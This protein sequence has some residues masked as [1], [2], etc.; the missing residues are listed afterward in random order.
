MKFQYFSIYIAEYIVPVISDMSFLDLFVFTLHWIAQS[1]EHDYQYFSH[2]KA[3]Y[4]HRL[5]Y[6]IKR[7]AK[8][9]FSS[10]ESAKIEHLHKHKN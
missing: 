7:C 5:I 3:I 4:A 1:V 9:A 6:K 2:E 10:C 8:I